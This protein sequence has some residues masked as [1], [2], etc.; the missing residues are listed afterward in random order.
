MGGGRALAALLVSVVLFECTL[1]AALWMPGVLEPM[2]YAN[3]SGTAAEL[4][5]TR[6]WLGWW[7]TEDKGVT[8]DHIEPSTLHDPL[9]GWVPQ[10]G[11]NEVDARGVRGPHPPR[12]PGGT[13]V[14]L[15]GD[16]FAWGS[17]V[18]AE[19]SIG[20]RLE[21]R[22]SDVD[23]LN[24]GVYGYGH[25]QILLRTQRDAPALHPDV[26]V[27]VG[28]GDDLLRNAEDW[29]AYARPRFAWDGTTLGQPATVPSPW[30]VVQRVS[31]RPRLVDALTI[32]REGGR[33]IPSGTAR[34]DLDALSAAILD[35]WAEAVRA[36]GATP[37]VVALPTSWLDPARRKDGGVR[38]DR[39]FWQTWCATATH[40]CVEG[41]DRFASRFEDPRHAMGAAHWSEAGYDAAAA[42]IA[43]VL[44]EEGLLP[45]RGTAP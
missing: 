12:I 38:D 32:W 35:A 15:V 26:V 2:T 23:V 14:V 16:S 24:L 30:E 43:D 9:L 45:A 22:R 18:P 21:S 29:F 41:Y 39:A 42:V 28:I 17:D 10:P 37:V 1:R 33:D 3:P 25:D 13:R 34:A 11:R 4:L 19:A 7:A 44:V 31:L 27:L 8:S 36:M 6:K 40:P 5:W 20:P